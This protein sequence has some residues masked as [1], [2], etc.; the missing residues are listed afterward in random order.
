LLS[1]CGEIADLLAAAIR[2]TAPCRRPALVGVDGPGCSG[3]STLA[4]ALQA[5]LP[6]ATVVSLDDFFIPLGQQILTRSLGE[7]LSTGV[8]HLRWNAIQ[9]LFRHIGAN[10][11]AAYAPYMWGADRLGGDVVVPRSQFVVIEGLYALHPQFRSAYAFKIWVD[12][13]T[14][15][16]MARVQDRMLRAGVTDGERWLHLWEELYVPR[17][18]A[19][20]AAF[21]PDLAADVFVMGPGLACGT[22][23]S[24]AWTHAGERRPTPCCSGRVARLRSGLAAERERG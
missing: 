17:E 24:Y 4:D 10:H 23:E 13:R 21:R 19:Y 15:D 5:A 18:Q 20:L 16:R 8:P 7:D 1:H 2:D 12:C 14:V 3:K 6:D 9:A 22:C 11:R